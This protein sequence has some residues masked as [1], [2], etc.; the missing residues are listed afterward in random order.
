MKHLTIETCK[1]ISEKLG[2]DVP[3]TE[4]FWSIYDGGSAEKN[5][6]IVFH[7]DANLGFMEDL[8]PAFGVEEI[9]MPNGI[10]EKLVI[11]TELSPFPTKTIFLTLWEDN[12]EEAEQYLI[13]LL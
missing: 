2:K 1:L 3:E 10:I 6:G 11:D 5:P 7:D 9:L 8:T 12:W 4:F 13:S